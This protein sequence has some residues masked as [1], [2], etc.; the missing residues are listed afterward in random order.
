MNGKYLTAYKA[1]TMDAVSVA[2]QVFGSEYTIEGSD[3]GV[4][5]RGDGVS[6]FV[7]SVD[8]SIREGDNS[9]YVKTAKVITSLYGGDASKLANYMWN[10]RPGQKHWDGIQYGKYYVVASS[11]GGVIVRW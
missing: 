1:P 5:I 10:A 7:G 4:Y 3:N 9:V 11:T 6:S 8:A 2:K